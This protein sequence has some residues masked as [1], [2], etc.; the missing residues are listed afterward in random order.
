MSFS[1][2]PQP[3]REENGI[4]E[5]DVQPS[6]RRFI[7]RPTCL[8]IVSRN[9]TLLLFL[10]DRYLTGNR[11]SSYRGCAAPTR[12]VAGTNRA[13]E[14]RA[15]PSRIQSR[16]LARLGISIE[17][18]RVLAKGTIRG[19][20]IRAR[21]GNQARFR[22]VA[23]LI[24]R[25]SRIAPLE[26]LLPMQPRSFRRAPLPALRGSHRFLQPAASRLD[27]TFAELMGGRAFA[28]CL[29]RVLESTRNK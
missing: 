25:L 13:A 10:S 7:S 21:K 4:E 1:L 2:F 18:P 28:F 5:G 17:K 27:S 19:T 16:F 15:H 20:S 8:T 6:C 12:R 9:N 26:T 11:Y 22:T 24:P 29:R 3:P 23:T 14:L